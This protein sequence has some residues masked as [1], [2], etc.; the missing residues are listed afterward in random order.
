MKPYTSLLIIRYAVPI[1]VILAT[2]FAGS[3][4]NVI[5]AQYSNW[6]RE[7]GL[8]SALAKVAV[9]VVE[10]KEKIIKFQSATL[11]IES[12]LKP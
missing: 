6:A 4:C 5:Y 12:I 9:P 2:I 1:R 8:H 7:K 10:W 3:V 11:V